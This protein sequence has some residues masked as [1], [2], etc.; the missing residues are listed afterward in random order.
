MAHS[1][2]VI[3]TDLIKSG[4]S[5]GASGHERRHDPLAMFLFRLVTSHCK[6]ISE[7]KIKEEKK[8]K[9]RERERDAAR[10]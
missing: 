7:N 6:R 4:W 1:E 2:S 3:A 10:L 5:H 8:R 9:K